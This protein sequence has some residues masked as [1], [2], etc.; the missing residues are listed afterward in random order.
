MAIHPNY[1]DGS[2]DVLLDDLLEPKRKLA[3]RLLLPPVQA[4]RDEQWFREQLGLSKMKAP[5]AELDVE[6]IEAM[7]LREFERWALARLMA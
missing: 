1:G 4:H 2:F 5:P 6:A 7:E 3:R